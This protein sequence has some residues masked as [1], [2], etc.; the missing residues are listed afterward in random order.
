MAIY[1]YIKAEPGHKSNILKWL[2]LLF[3]VS[4]LVLITNVTLPIFLYQLRSKTKFSP[5]LLIPITETNAQAVGGDSFLDYSQ[6]RAWF[7]SAPQLPPQ[8]SKIT[9]YTLSIPKL[10]IEEATVEI[11]GSDLMKSLVQYP[12]TV[13]PGQY[14]NTVIFGHSVLPQFFN[15]KNYKTIFSTLP[16][17]EVGDDIFVNFDGVFYHYQVAEMTEVKPQDVSV[18]AQYYD[19]QYLTLITCAPPGTYLWRL[20]IRAK[21]V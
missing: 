9:H 13:M 10:K 4:G 1:C 15:P 11:G 19:N 7:P 16:K 18:L 2:P 14:G 21:L 20:I 17:M 12:G 3:L 5:K 6:P 8:S